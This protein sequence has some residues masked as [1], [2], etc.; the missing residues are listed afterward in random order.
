LIGFIA[1]IGFSVGLFFCAVLWPP[2]E[3]PSE[4]STDAAESCRRA[5]GDHGGTRKI[6]C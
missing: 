1:A 2:R 4:T 3:L 6:P 5:V